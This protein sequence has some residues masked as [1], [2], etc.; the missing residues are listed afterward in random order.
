MEIPSDE[1]VGEIGRFVEDTVSLVRAR[2]G[3]TGSSHA[4]PGE[5]VVLEE[6]FC[7]LNP[8]RHDG[9]GAVLGVG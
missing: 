4:I 6:T 9:C 3:Q 2:Q 1:A 7:A 5:A 8:A